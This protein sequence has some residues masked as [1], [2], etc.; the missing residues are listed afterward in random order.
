[1]IGMVIQLAITSMVLHL[2][3]GISIKIYLPRVVHNGLTV[4]CIT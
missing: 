4:L 2:S 3:S 1:M